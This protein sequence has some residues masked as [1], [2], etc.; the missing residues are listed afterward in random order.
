MSRQK[1]QEQTQMVQC[2]YY[3]TFCWFTGFNMKAL[4]VFV[5]C[6]STISY[7]EGKLS[8][9]PSSLLSIRCHDYIRCGL[10]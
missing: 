7:I 10:L 9:L 8:H 1:M 6:L 5:V 3:C 2:K 4:I